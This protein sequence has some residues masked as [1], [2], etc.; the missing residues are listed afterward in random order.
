MLNIV[1][2]ILISLIYKKINNIALFGAIVVWNPI[3]IF[4]I[5]GLTL[6][7]GDLLFGALPVVDYEYTLWD[8]V[9]RHSRRFLIA[10][11]IIAAV[12]AALSYVIV[13]FSVYLIQKNRSHVPN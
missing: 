13:Y 5:Y 2:C 11:C 1:I 6:K 7:F 9:Y 8:Q 10:L 3:V 12:I 4:P